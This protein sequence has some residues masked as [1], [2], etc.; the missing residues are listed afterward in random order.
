[1]DGV[2]SLDGRQ[3]DMHG[4]VRTDAR[5]SEMVTGWKSWLLKAVDPFLAKNGA[6]MEVPIQI[7]GTRS[8][9]H[10]GLD[11]HHQ[12]QDKKLLK[13]NQAPQQTLRPRSMRP[14]ARAA[15]SRRTTAPNNRS[16]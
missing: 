1:M 9:P 3:F 10:F 8:D 5:A 16:A 12:A 11:F 2:Y 4:M 13:Q 14:K 15:E 6:G 7:T